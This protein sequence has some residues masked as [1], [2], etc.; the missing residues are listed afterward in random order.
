[1]LHVR[2]AKFIH[3]CFT[4]FAAILFLLI[5]VSQT[6]KNV[7]FTPFLS[8]ES[9]KVGQF[10]LDKKTFRNMKF[11]GFIL[12]LN[13]RG[14]SW[15]RFVHFH[16]FQKIL[17]QISNSVSTFIQQLVY[18]WCPDPIYGVD[19]YISTN[20]TLGK[21]SKTS[22]QAPSYARRLQSESIAHW[23]THWHG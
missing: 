6:V 8:F 3:L 13:Q 9:W 19:M 23:L 21:S 2:L 16:W 18:Q 22:S 11:C 7:F 14:L 12:D 4:F 5:Y 20:N 17:W 15:L 10:I 1:M